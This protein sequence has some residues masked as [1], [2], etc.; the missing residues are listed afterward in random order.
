MRWCGGPRSLIGVNLAQ[1]GAVPPTRSRRRDIAGALDRLSAYDGDDLTVIIET[2]K[3]SQNKYAFE[4]R[5]GAF[6]L[7]GV[8]PA[9]AVF[10]FDF[11]FVPSTRG[12]D[13]DPL[14]IL[15]LMD[16]S[17][18][19]GCIV[20]SRLIGA[21]QAEQTE[22][23]K[24]ERNDRLLA[25]AANSITHKSIKNLNAVGDDLLGQI[26]HFFVSYNMAKGKQFVPIGRVGPIAARRLV[27]RAATRAKRR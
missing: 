9:G 3:G 23:G 6:V 12:D 22:D 21:I 2:P 8:L 17:A 15:V 5:L 16:A 1:G 20:P 19:A 10:P 14:D 7:K 27:E 4:P 11:G 24:T 18:F 25:V 26:E 13:G